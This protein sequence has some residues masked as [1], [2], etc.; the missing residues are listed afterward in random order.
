MKNNSLSKSFTRYAAIQALYNFNFSENLDDIKKYLTAEKVFFID[1]NLE[2]NFKKTKMNKNFF[3][4]K[5]FRF[6]L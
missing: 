2:V 4:F 1:S 5:N 3:F 6:F